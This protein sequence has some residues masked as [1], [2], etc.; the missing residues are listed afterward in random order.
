[1]ENSRRCNICNIIVRRASYAKHLRSENH[2]EDIRQDHKIIPEWFF[3]EEQTP[4]KKKKL[5]YK[6]KT[7]KQTARE[8]NKIDDEK[9]DNQLVLKRLIHIISLL[10][11]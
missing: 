7:L 3:K 1:M 6:P 11:T 9:L 5:V 4:I 2:L 10:K 8:N